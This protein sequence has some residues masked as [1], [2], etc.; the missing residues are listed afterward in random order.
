MEKKNIDN[1]IREVLAIEA[2]EAKK[3]GSIGYMARALVQATLPHRKVAGNEF[4]RVNGAFKLTILSDSET[5]LPYGSVPR[6]LLA[7]IST[8][9]VRTKKRH[10]VLGRTLSAFM[11]ELDLIPTG[12][13]WGTI[14]RLKDQMRRLFSSHISCAYTGNE[15]W[16]IK[17]ITIVNSA[18]LW[19]SPKIPNQASIFDSTI[20]LNECFFEE[21]INNP[22]PVDLRA[23]KA[24]KRSPLAID[25]YC[26]ITYR[27]SY[28]RMSTTIPWDVLQMQFGSNY[29]SNEQGKRNFKRH[30]LKEL[31][32]VSCLH[33]AL[34][35][36]NGTNGLTIKPGKPHISMHNTPVGKKVIH[37]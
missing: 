9:A 23:L 12:G 37:A 13:R 1:L 34:N 21:I 19:W 30:F 18:D 15:N 35:V 10:L 31:H 25:I 36:E 27:V 5:G 24:L 17:N 29:L 2:E 32:K 4:K 6:L 33:S 11:A 14:T 22:V 7:W 8:E 26:W 20:T 16:S 28:L 3:A